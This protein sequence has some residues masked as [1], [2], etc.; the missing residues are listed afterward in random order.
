MKLA[1]RLL[2]TPELAQYF[3]GDML[4]DPQGRKG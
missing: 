4:P 2:H 1:R 3:D